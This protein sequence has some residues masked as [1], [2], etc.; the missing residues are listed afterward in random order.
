MD[1]SV[2]FNDS[3]VGVILDKVQDVD[4]NIS[5]NVSSLTNHGTTSVYLFS[6]T[7]AD[8]A[9]FATKHPTKNTLLASSD[10]VSVY[11]LTTGEIQIN[12]GPDFEGKT[13]VKILNGIPWSTIYGYTIDAQ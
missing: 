10:G 12:A 6:I 5:M 2:S 7:Q 3:N 13:H 4:G 9:A 1:N 8:L 11:L